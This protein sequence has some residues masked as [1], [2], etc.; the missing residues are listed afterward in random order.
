MSKSALTTVRDWAGLIAS[1]V[2][3]LF[4]MLYPHGQPAEGFGKN[5]D[6]ET[7]AEL[8]PQ[9]ATANPVNAELVGFDTAYGH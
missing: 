5:R 9:N 7:L 8:R 1:I 3:V 4:I 6:R 2:T